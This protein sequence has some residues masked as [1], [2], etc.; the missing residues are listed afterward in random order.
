MKKPYKLLIF[1][2][3]FQKKMKHKSIPTRISMKAPRKD[4]QEEK[5]V[6]K[7]KKNR[8]LMIIREIRRLQRSTNLVIPKS[9]FLRLVKEIMKDLFP[10]DN[11]RMQSD[12]VG[13]IHEA[14][15]AFLVNLM[16]NSYLCTI[17]GKR[18]TLQPKDIQ[19]VLKLI[20]N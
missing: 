2:Q 19:L 8:K 7:R 3:Q 10:S 20:K 14:T 4:L 17:H 16:E 11:Y 9:A 12:A 6:V 5:P 18:T 13:A 1:S 15:E